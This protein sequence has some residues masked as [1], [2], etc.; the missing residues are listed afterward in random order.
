M[1]TLVCEVPILRQQGIKFY[2]A[3]LY[4]KT[5]KDRV[6]YFPNVVPFAIMDS[7]AINCL[8]SGQEECDTLI[9]PFLA[10]VGAELT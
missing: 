8:M 3:L 2:R 5:C 7:K 4:W 6:S 10:L 9:I 1:K